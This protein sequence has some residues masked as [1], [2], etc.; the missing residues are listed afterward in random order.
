MASLGSAS[1]QAG[2]APKVVAS[3]LQAFLTGVPIDTGVVLTKAST[4]APK[5][6]VN[7]S[8]TAVPIS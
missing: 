1:L 5:R 3:D 2:I 8:G 4:V 7:V 6:Y